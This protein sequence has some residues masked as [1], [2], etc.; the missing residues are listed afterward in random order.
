[1]ENLTLYTEQVNHSADSNIVNFGGGTERAL[2]SVV[3]PNT[4]FKSVIYEGTGSNPSS[5]SESYNLTV[6]PIN[7]RRKDE[8]LPLSQ[9]EPLILHLEDDLH[10]E[11]GKR[12]S[13][14]SP[15]IPLV[16]VYSSN[17]FIASH[18]LAQHNID[19]VIPPTEQLVHSHSQKNNSDNPSHGYKMENKASSPAAGEPTVTLLKYPPD[20]IT[21]FTE[22]RSYLDSNPTFPHQ[23]SR[24]STY[25]FSDSMSAAS[26][27][28][29][30]NVSS[31]TFLNK[32]YVD[33]TSSLN[34]GLNRSNTTADQLAWAY[35]TSR[36][37]IETASNA[38]GCSSRFELDS[39][40]SEQAETM[41]TISTVS[42][43][44][45]EMFRIRRLL[46]MDSLSSPEKHTRQTNATKDIRDATNSMKNITLHEVESA[47][48]QIHRLNVQLQNS[49]LEKEKYRLESLAAETKAS[50]ECQEKYH[51][52]LRQKA[53]T[54]GRLEAVQKE[55]EVL[56]LDLTNKT[57][58]IHTE[59]KLRSANQGKIVLQEMEKL[60]QEH[61]KLSQVNREVESRN[62]DLS[63]KLEVKNS[64]MERFRNDLKE[65]ETIN[66]KLRIELNELR[67]ETDS[68]DGAIQGLK[69]K[70][71]D[72]HIELQALLQ[73]KLKVENNLTSL[74]NEVESVRK[75][76]HWYRDQLHACQT[77]KVKVQQ[78][79]MSSQSNLVSHSHLV[80]KLKSEVANLQQ[81]CEETHQR[82][83]KEKETMMSKLEAIQADMV[84]RETIILGQIRQEDSSET[85]VTIAA[86]LKKIEEEKQTHISASNLSVQDLEQQVAFLY[87][88]LSA[89]DATIGRIE[90]ENAQIMVRV[91]T[92]QKT[93]NERELMYQNLENKCRNFETTL[94]GVEIN[95]KEKEHL[96][97]EV[98]NEK[99]NLEVAL[100]A[101]AR[102]KIEVESAIETLR[103]DFAHITKSY[104]VMKVEL[105]NK[106]KHMSNLEIQLRELTIER[107]SLI[108]QLEALDKL[109]EEC[110]EMRYRI[111][112]VETLESHSEH[113]KVCNQ[114]LINKITNLNQALENA[115]VKGAK[116]EETLTFREQQLM[117]QARSFEVHKDDLQAK[118]N[119]ISNLHRD[120]Q[121]LENKLKRSQAKVEALERLNTKLSADI[122]SVNKQ[123]EQAN[124][125]IEQFNLLCRGSEEE[126]NQLS[127][128]LKQVSQQLHE[129][130]LNKH[131]KHTENNQLFNMVENNTDYDHAK[132]PRENLILSGENGFVHPVF[133]RIF[134]L[135]EEI[136]QKIASILENKHTLTIDEKSPHKVPELQALCS[137]LTAASKCLD[138]VQERK[139]HL[140]RE[141]ENLQQVQRNLEAECEK[142]REPRRVL[143]DHSNVFDITTQTIS[144]G[145]EEKY[146]KQI[147]S[148]RKEVDKM[149]AMLRLAETEHKEKHRRYE[150]NVRTLLK[151]VKE[152]MRGRK[153]AEKQLESM[154]VH[155]EEGADTGVIVLK[156]EV[157]RLKCECEALSSKYDEQKK[158]TDKVEQAMLELERERGK[159]LESTSKEQEI[160]TTEDPPLTDLL[161]HRARQ[162]QLQQSQVVVAE[163]QDQI[164]KCNMIIKDL[165]KEVFN[166]KCETSQLK[167]QVSSLRMGLE[168]ANDVLDNKKI[169][170]GRAESMCEVLQAT[171]AR[172]HKDLEEEQKSHEECRE[173]VNRLRDQLEESRAKDPVLA[174]Q[175]KASALEYIPFRGLCL[176]YYLISYHLHQ[177]T[178]EANGLE[179][180]I[181][182]VEERWAAREI[183]LNNTIAT[184]NHDVAALRSDL[185]AVR[186]DKFDLQRQAAELRAVLHS[187]SENTKVLRLKLEAY[188]C[189]SSKDKL[190]DLTSSL[191]SPPAQYDET[192]I[193][194]LL[195]QSTVLPLNKPLSNLR[196]C[197][198]SLKIEMAMLQRQIT[199]KTSPNK[200]NGCSPG[201]TD[202]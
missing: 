24:Q 1:M 118:E 157:T 28:N 80:E 191:P 16:H 68:K 81:D 160:P 27:L 144:T 185:E 5:P 194:A 106:E 10:Q 130:N 111:Q 44:E 112:S 114:E 137:N 123:L 53:L 145:E 141:I 72:Q 105:R 163:L 90:V 47:D 2:D 25:E 136:R 129:T 26:K 88:E 183:T 91:T 188:G 23:G 92:I 4:D 11:L 87:R 63:W 17:T 184:L 116:Q 58:T 94:N 84:E 199:E 6:D 187:S 9:C 21:V 172:L 79:L 179:K 32:D 74:K 164:H 167:K 175:I 42:G 193:S 33:S 57:K 18:G 82:A 146:L 190:P 168:T 78:E 161:E 29:I 142:M 138:K 153:A 150:A 108:S 34:H 46:L 169:D 41:S 19:R 51:E 186:Q 86:K 40:C 65:M 98:K 115:Q 192:L 43:Y 182:L 154:R 127:V 66:E 177:K 22:K 60:A 119:T 30:A 101:A 135:V 149:K 76:S 148:N 15:C 122:L 13:L 97:H 147:E 189:D 95:L 158:A 109:K 36:D 124:G 73:A 61:A 126:K 103:E 70:V 56:R 102:E 52:I 35:R 131:I 200:G 31:N 197:L 45:E 12:K 195:Q 117:N 54:E 125:V 96:L 89:K 39:N 3:D 180:K 83:V 152:H 8:T 133:N 170:L 69:T 55:V 166:E 134:E 181:S 93:L 59:N 49:L 113:L 62:Q 107:D 139:D 67:V 48:I 50:L 121:E 38:S 110:R 196:S 155:P 132:I 159:L 162:L 151:K 104:Q 201:V 7:V 77:A 37:R 99:V 202:V 174:D 71:A 120:K 178:Q 171:N 173:Q 176:D 14:D 85:M 64:E 100:S 156:A 20:R 143:T 198:D 128:R 165:R 75:S 140:V